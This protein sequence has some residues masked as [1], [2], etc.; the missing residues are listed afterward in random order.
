MSVFPLFLLFAQRNGGARLI[1][2]THSRTLRIHRR[3]RIHHHPR[4][5]T[6]RTRATSITVVPRVTYSPIDRHT[7]A[8]QR[9][10]GERYQKQH[11][12]LRFQLLSCFLSVFFSRPSIP[13]FYAAHWVS[14]AACGQLTT[15]TCIYGVLLMRRGYDTHEFTL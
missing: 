5:S 1:R 11:H 13:L 4:R 6:R 8:Y 7:A 12:I 15:R 14:V 3:T 10:E 9:F 2:P